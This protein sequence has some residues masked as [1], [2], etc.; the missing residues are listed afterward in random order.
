MKKYKCSGCYHKCPVTQDEHSDFFPINCLYFKEKTAFWTEIKEEKE[1][2]TEC[3]QLPD[4]CEVGKRVYNI[5][6]KQYQTIRRINGTVICKNIDGDGCTQYGYG[7]FM[8]DCVQARKRPFNE[9][10]MKALVGKV[11]EN[12]KYLLWVEGYEKN[13]KRI[14]TL[15]KSFTAEELMDSDYLI[16]RA[17]CYKLE[18]LNENG[19][20]VE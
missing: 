7:A 15:L 13:T 5:K 16:D 19:E 1:T 17:P 11:L 8:G 4:W 12:H 2:V 20:W 6:K 14:V 18:H 10:E 9:K 3:N